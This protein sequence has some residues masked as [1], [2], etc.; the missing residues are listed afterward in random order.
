MRDI[1]ELIRQ[2]ETDIGRFEKEIERV[3]KELD[4]L[5]LA[6]KLLDEGAEVRTTTVAAA[7][8]ARE[9]QTYG[10]TPAPRPASAPSPAASPS[11]WAS[12]KQFP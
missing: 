4:A 2:K 7:T 6:A 12:A 3:R 9:T 5:R 11:A 1:Y 10:P 8:V